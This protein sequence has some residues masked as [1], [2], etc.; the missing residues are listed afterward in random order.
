MLQ[1]FAEVSIFDLVDP[2]IIRT[3]LEVIRPDGVFYV[4]IREAS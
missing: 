4:G 3:D 1:C 2:I